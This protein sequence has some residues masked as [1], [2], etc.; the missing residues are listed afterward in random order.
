[1]AKININ[2]SEITGRV[3]DIMQRNGLTKYA[4]AQKI[5][6]E[7]SAISRIFQGKQSWTLD[8]IYNIGVEFGVSF[9]Y[10]LLGVNRVGELEQELNLARN[11]LTKLLEEKN[12]RYYQKSE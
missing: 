5:N 11:Y 12:E 9:D 10:L 4:L 6:V 3:V 1:M 7:R 2:N 8:I